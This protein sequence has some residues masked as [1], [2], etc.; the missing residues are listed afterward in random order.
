MLDR[1]RFFV[2]MFF[3][4]IFD[5]FGVDLAV[6]LGGFPCPDKPSKFFPNLLYA[7]MIARDTSLELKSDVYVFDEKRRHIMNV[8]DS[9]SIL[10]RNLQR[11]GQCSVNHAG[12]IYVFGGI[13]FGKGNLG[14][15][16]ESNVIKIINIRT[17]EIEVQT[18]VSAEITTNLRLHGRFLHACA[19][20]GS[21][22]YSFG[23]CV[24][25]RQG[26]SCEST[27]ELIVFNL[28]RR[29]WQMIN[30]FESPEPRSGHA[31][32]IAQEILYVFGGFSSSGEILKSVNDL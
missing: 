22:L 5:R 1:Y 29:E 3:A 30:S 28:N 26:A 15:E 8:S 7:G 16:L 4:S 12:N 18:F 21:S 6:I 17:E 31:M 24:S 27:N 32:T 25:E 23:G 13:S 11:F 19:L 20:N 9:Q 10:K 14:P 2:A